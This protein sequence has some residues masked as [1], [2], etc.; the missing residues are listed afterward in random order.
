MRYMDDVVKLRSLLDERG[1]AWT[2]VPDATLALYP[3]AETLPTLTYWGDAGDAGNYVASVAYGG[4]RVDPLT[5]EQVVLATV[6]APVCHP[7]VN[8][9]LN[10]TEGAGDAWANCSECGALLCVLTDSGS[11]MPNYCPNCGCHVEM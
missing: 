8:D 4:L 3:D 9:N 7:I 11:V 6:G 10:E 2:K 5:P 1:V